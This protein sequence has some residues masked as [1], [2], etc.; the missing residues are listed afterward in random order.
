M[1]VVT[2]PALCVVGH[3]R[4]G[5]LVWISTTSGY[6]LPY[7]RFCLCLH[8]T[9]YILAKSVRMASIVG[10]V[11]YS[12]RLHDRWWAQPMAS[13]LHSELVVRGLEPPSSLWKPVR[14]QWS[15]LSPARSLGNTQSPLTTSST[16]E[17][18]G[19]ELWFFLHN[20][21]LASVWGRNTGSGM[22]HEEKDHTG[23]AYTTVLP[24]VMQ[25]RHKHTVWIVF[26]F[27][28][29]PAVDS[30]DWECS[31][32]RLEGRKI[33]QAETQPLSYY[34]PKW[35]HIWVCVCV[36]LRNREGILYVREL[37]VSVR[38]WLR[39]WVSEIVTQ[40]IRLVT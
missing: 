35:N 24:H 26:F 39:E 25:K 34:S 31:R 32:R 18:D 28:S 5:R 12:L 38:V 21:L 13:P 8:T 23:E 3:S 20:K 36:S 16:V 4:R 22:V 37:C 11:E 19:T 14:L 10:G 1:A 2:V 40:Y 9:C 15:D 27:W 17:D 29:Q 7:C 33:C 30:H 6:F